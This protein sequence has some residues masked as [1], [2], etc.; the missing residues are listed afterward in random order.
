ML[1]ECLTSMTV[2]GH[3][4]GYRR[5]TRLYNLFINRR[6]F[7]ILVNVYR[8]DRQF[9]VNKVESM[10]CFSLVIGAWMHHVILPFDSSALRVCVWCAHTYTLCVAYQCRTN[11]MHFLRRRKMG[12]NKIASALHFESDLE[13][14]SFHLN[15]FI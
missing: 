12:W 3:H 6:T 13:L 15:F 11:R 9:V 4:Q 1:R 14:W 7:N 10:S 8:N 5:P 2:A